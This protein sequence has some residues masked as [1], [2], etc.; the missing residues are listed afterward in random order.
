MAERLA[1]TMSA[2]PD[3]PYQLTVMNPTLILGPQLPGQPHLNTSSSAVVA[4]LDG[5]MREIENTSRTI[6]DVRDVAEAHV[7]ALERSEAAGRRFL[8]IG[9]SAHQSDIAAA[10]RASLPADLR[11]HVPTELC[12]T[13]PPHVMAQPPPLPILFDASPSREVLGVQYRSVQEMVHTAVQTLLANGFTNNKS[14]YSTDN[15]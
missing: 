5:S 14:M 15:L 12:A 8:L 13:L 2:A 9:A 10:V 7:N 1:W 11:H 4:F 3:C 6:V